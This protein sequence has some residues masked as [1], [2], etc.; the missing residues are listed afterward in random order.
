MNHRVVVV[1][2]LYLGFVAHFARAQGS[3][4][5]GN[6]GTDLSY[7]IQVTLEHIDRIA[8]A[9]G[10]EAGDSQ[11]I[12][13]GAEEYGDQKFYVLLKNLDTEERRFCEKHIKS[14]SKKI[15]QL[16]N[17]KRLPAI[18][19]THESISISENDR[20][21]AVD[22]VSNVENRNIHLNEKTFREF[23]DPYKVSLLVHELIHFIDFEGR[24]LDDT[25]TV[26]PFETSRKFIDSIGAVFAQTLS[27]RSD[28]MLSNARRET[29]RYRHQ[30]LWSMNL[31]YPNVSPEDQTFIPNDLSGIEL[32]LHYNVSMNHSL[33]VARSYYSSEEESLNFGGF[34]LKKQLL[35]NSWDLG[36]TYRQR[37]STTLFST[38][39]QWFLG[40]SL[41]CSRRSWEL[42]VAD[43][44][45]VS[46]DEQITTLGPFAGIMV[47]IPIRNGFWFQSGY[48]MHQHSGKFSKLNN[49][50][51]EKST[52]VTLGVSYAH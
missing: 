49:Q 21:I 19:F 7:D 29:S 34:R 33:S 2:A 40:Y 28:L 8:R 16:V 13:E 38:F 37:F 27:E 3:T 39:R 46:I 18:T 44:S 11:G 5:V 23:E 51:I 41:G 26:G 35:M 10:H 42:K 9:L 45:Q 4:F 14:V 30:Y 50:K 32:R 15:T 36:Y 22:A 31:N 6:G 12:C 25:S 17:S 1:L 20:V 48:S 24:L 52:M 47:Y 43:D